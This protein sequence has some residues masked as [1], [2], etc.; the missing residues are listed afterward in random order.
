MWSTQVLPAAALHCSSDLQISQSIKELY[1]SFPFPSF[2][3]SLFPPFFPP[4]FPYFSFRKVF[5]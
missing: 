5:V 2:L 1:G 3:A 4:F